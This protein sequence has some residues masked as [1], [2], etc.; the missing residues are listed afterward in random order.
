MYIYIS[1]RKDNKLSRSHKTVGEFFL[2]FCLLMEGPEQINTDPDP[3]G[4]NDESYISETLSR[5]TSSAAKF[6]S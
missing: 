3:G 6:Y 4:K 5:T 1:L 2:F